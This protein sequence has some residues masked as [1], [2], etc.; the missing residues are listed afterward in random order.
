MNFTVKKN[1]KRKVTA[2]NPGILKYYLV[3]SKLQKKLNLL[4]R[5]NKF[6]MFIHEV[7]QL[8]NDKRKKISLSCQNT[9][10]VLYP[11]HNSPL[12]VCCNTV[13]ISVSKL[14]H[15]FSS[16]GLKVLMSNYTRWAIQASWEPLVLYHFHYELVLSLF[17]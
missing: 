11:Y 15:V 9:A 3:L 1:Y 10:L 14:K 8:R 4:V 12:L 17:I 5:N 2:I 16:P 6:W 7:L 13:I